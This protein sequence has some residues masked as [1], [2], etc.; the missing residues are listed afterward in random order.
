MSKQNNRSLLLAGLLIAGLTSPWCVAAT[1]L[2]APTLKVPKVR[3]PAVTDAPHVADRSPTSIRTEY[4]NRITKAGAVTVVGRHPDLIAV[5][6]SAP[7]GTHHER[8]VV[9]FRNHVP[10]RRKLA[11]SKLDRYD[12]ELSHQDLTR[13]TGIPLLIDRVPMGR[14]YDERKS[15]EWATLAQGPRLIPPSLVFS[16]EQQ[17]ARD[18]LKMSKHGPDV[19][20]VEQQLDVVNQLLSGGEV[21]DWRP[22]FE[23]SPSQLALERADA[24]KR[25]RQ[26]MA[27]LANYYMLEFKDAEAAWA[28][29]EMLLGLELV[30]AAYFP[31]VPKDADIA[32]TTGDFEPNQGYLES[33]AG[34]NGID[35]RYA[36]DFEGGRGELVRIID[37][38]A[39]W[40]PGHE[41]LPDA[42]Y[43]S[44]FNFWDSDHGTAVL[45]VMVALDDGAGITGIANEADF[46][47]A[48]V[49]NG[50]SVQFDPSLHVANVANAINQAAAALNPGDIILIEQHARGPG[51]DFGCTCNCSQWRFVPMEYWQAEF[52][53]IANT[54]ARGI[55]VVEAAGNGGQNLD[56]SRYDNRFNRSIRDSG[57]ILVGGGS[58]NNRSPM[59]WTN[60]GSRLDVQGWGQNVMTLG[61]G[62]IQANGNDI[63]QWYTNAFNGT[64][65]ASPIVAGAAAVLQGIRKSMGG[66]P[67]EPVELRDLLVANGNAQNG[68]RQI[69][70]LP[71]LRATLD[72]LGIT[73]DNQD[74]LTNEPSSDGSCTE[75]SS[76]SGECGG[77]ACVREVAGYVEGNCFLGIP[78]LCDDGYLLYHT[79]QFVCAD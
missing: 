49:I 22:L 42:F 58:S 27:D 55:V 6:P 53:A 4:L 33:S 31:P 71:D 34:S 7:P 69:G 76:A 45:G 61:Y 21:T 17:T 65:S 67:F 74:D 46:G 25:R 9:K 23:R 47:F 51:S 35:A 29:R 57:A 43:T 30:E 14:T 75:L 48:S 50:I 70:P 64:S 18:R 54:T 66:L 15:N 78:F 26:E 28:A 32:P 62:V 52:D 63:D 38:E 36:W 40:N 2:Y 56:H 5:A 39:G 41:D 8:L 73:L 44:G 11:L 68:T 20:L 72:S 59:C 24:E 10:V 13:H 12:I 79:D 60:F 3:D 77:K 19:A 1:K 37:I 16:A